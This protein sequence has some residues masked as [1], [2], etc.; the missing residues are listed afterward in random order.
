MSVDPP[1]LPVLVWA[2]LVVFVIYLGAMMMDSTSV[3]PHSAVANGTGAFSNAASSQINRY[4]HL[5]HHPVDRYT[6]PRRVSH[7]GTRYAATQSWWL[8]GTVGAANYLRLVYRTTAWR[9]GRG[10]IPG[11]VDL[12]NRPK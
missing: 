11:R 1:C 3:K 9:G 2:L 8:P 10:V 12:P 5:H 6:R 7:H 4:H